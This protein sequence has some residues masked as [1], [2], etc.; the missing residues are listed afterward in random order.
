MKWK[1]FPDR[2]YYGDY[3]VYYVEYDNFG[4][5]RSVLRTKKKYYVYDNIILMNHGDDDVTPYIIRET[6][7]Y[8]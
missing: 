6:R 4:R 8:Y 3:P 1:T 5:R 7:P 2:A